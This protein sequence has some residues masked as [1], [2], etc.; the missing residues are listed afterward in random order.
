MIEVAFNLDRYTLECAHVAAHSLALYTSEPVRVLFL[1]ESSASELPAGW[2]ERFENLSPN[3]TVEFVVVDNTAFRHCKSFFGSHATYLRV[4]APRFAKSSRIIYSDTDV[5]FTSDVRELR[6][7]PMKGAT[8][9]LPGGAP[10]SGRQEIE[11]EALLACGRGRDE[12]YYGSGLA[13]IDA[14]KYLGSGK[15]ERCEEVARNMAPH[16]KFHEQTIWN[17]AFTAAE[18]RGLDGKWC[19]TP[20]VGGGRPFNADPGIV[21]FAGSPK[22]WDLLGEFCHGAYPI[23]AAAARKARHSPRNVAKY[24]DSSKLVR[25]WRIRRQ[26]AA[27]IGPI[28]NKL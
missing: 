16:L 25:A 17:C 5:V 9:A 6:D 11:K 20:P 23:W 4:Y 21:H 15:V 1:I 10:I 19:Q 26:Y 12:Q 28:A 7:L 13:V 22:P 14:A 2:R 18:I 24:F 8:I 3:A 27:W